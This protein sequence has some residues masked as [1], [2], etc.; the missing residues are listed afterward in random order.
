MFG[1]RFPLPS[2]TSVVSLPST[3]MCMALFLT[4]NLLGQSCAADDVDVRESVVKIETTVF[5][6]ELFEPWNPGVPKKRSATGVIIEGNRILTS[7]YIVGNARTITV[8][9]FQSAKKVT[10]KVIS[11]SKGQDLAVLSV[12]DKEFFEGRPALPFCDELPAVKDKVNAFGY[13]LG[14]TEV[15]VTEGIVSRI[16]FNEYYMSARGLRIQIDAALNKGNGGGPAVKDGKMVGTVFSRMTEADNIGYLIP[17]EE[18]RMF[19]NDIKDGS[20]DG[21][22]VLP[23]DIQTQRLENEAIRKK[24]GLDNETG[25]VMIYEVAPNKNKPERDKRDTST[26]QAWDVITKIDGKVIDREGNIPLGEGNRVS[27][28][29]LIQKHTDN[30][31]VP[32]TLLRDGKEIEANIKL[33]RGGVKLARDLEYEPTPYMIVG[34]MVFMPVTSELAFAMASTK[35]KWI[36]T[37][38]RCQN[39][40]LLQGLSPRTEDN[41][42]LELVI[43]GHSFLPHPITKGYS[44]PRFGVIKKFNDVEIKNLKHLVELMRDNKKEYFIFEY[45]GASYETCVFDREEFLAATEEVL[46]DNGIRRQGTP[47]L[48]KVWNETSSE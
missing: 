4:I 23:G 41:E 42:D 34:P 43:T 8:Q 20:Y 1:I 18:I 31:T 28:K 36:G 40:A 13:P 30:D 25:G 27:L 47:E 19:L 46:D 24:L 17:I 16:E 48:L 35:S 12:D 29:Y 11:L 44:D 14:G 7:G 33:R 39:P 5:L 21:K 10:A 26:L 22:L 6:P 9:G 37:F 45:A 38:N 2:Q 3:C 15:S 32:M